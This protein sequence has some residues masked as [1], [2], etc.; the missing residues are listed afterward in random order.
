ME[1]VAVK[2]QAQKILIL[3]MSPLSFP[4]LSNGVNFIRKNHAVKFSISEKTAT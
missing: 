3:R 1:T 4:G 2:A